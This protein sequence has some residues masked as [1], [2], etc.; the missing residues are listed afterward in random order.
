[1]GRGRAASGAPASAA[2]CPPATLALRANRPRPSSARA[3]CARARPLSSVLC[4]CHRGADSVVGSS[5]LDTDTACTGVSSHRI[6][7]PVKSHQADSRFSTSR[8]VVHG[9]L[10]T[11]GF[12][13]AG[14][15]K[16]VFLGTEEGRVWHAGLV[17]DE[18]RR[19]AQFRRRDLSVRSARGSAHL[20]GCSRGLDRQIVSLGLR[21]VTTGSERPAQ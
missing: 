7:V 11:K 2:D 18:R 3:G 21:I 6:G 10:G 15:K 12:K 8:A 20:L 1:M 14:P 17:T 9:V 5:P 13:V 19:L 16:Q 4:S